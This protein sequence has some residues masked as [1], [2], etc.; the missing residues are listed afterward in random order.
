MLAVLGGPPANPSSAHRE[1]A[2]ARRR[3]R[4][5]APRWRPDRGPGRRDHAHERRHGGEQPGAPRCA[6]GR[7]LARRHRRDARSSMPRC[8]RPRRRSPRRAR[9][10]PSCRSTPS[11]RVDPDAWRQ[12][13][14]SAR[15]LVSVGLA[16]GEIGIVAPIA[17][18]AAAL[19]GRG[20]LLHTDAAQAAGRCRSTWRRSASIC[21][22][23]RPQARRT[24]GR[25]A[26][27]V[28]P[29][30][31]A[32]PARHRRPAGARAA[33]GDRERGRAGRVRCGARA[34]RRWS[35]PQAEARMAALLDRL[36]EGIVRARARRRAAR[37]GGGTS[38]PEHAERGLRPDA[39][40]RACSCCSTWR[41][42]RS[43]SAR[44]VRR[45]RRSRRTCCARSAATTKRRAAASAS[46]SVRPPPPRR[47][48]VVGRAAAR[49]CAVRAVTCAPEVSA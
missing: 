29:R 5:H 14:T 10:R 33:R 20:I 46:A 38:P 2:R 44:R 27:W 42:S 36:W 26:L 41:A 48:S 47:S 7:G 43:R 18:I 9:A 6:G 21:C 12:R 31:R 25:R 19:R 1:G 24:A 23:C 4:R 13:V 34:R 15:R 30:R 3:S 16:N 22:R 39:R 11:G 37:S 35:S 32:A 49:W 40:A 8:S 17:A 45:A 28:R